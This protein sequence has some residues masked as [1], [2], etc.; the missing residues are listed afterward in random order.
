MTI[1][2]YRHFCSEK[3]NQLR[4]RTIGRIG[5]LMIWLFPRLC[6]HSLYTNPATGTA[7]TRITKINYPKEA[8][9]IDAS[10]WEA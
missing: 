10:V 5:P 6:N 2:L 4:K 3:F 7:N 9:N 1:R 8:I